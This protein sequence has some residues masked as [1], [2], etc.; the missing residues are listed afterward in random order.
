MFIVSEGVTKNPSQEPG[1]RAI[2]PALAGLIAF[3]ISVGGL[4]RVSGREGVDWPLLLYAAPGL[5]AG[6]AGIWGG[7]RWW[8]ASGALLLPVGVLGLIGGY[9]LIWIWAGATL[10]LLGLRKRKEE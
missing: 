3:G 10:L 5:L 1:R 9:G 4:F 7:R 8:I 6:P 2:L